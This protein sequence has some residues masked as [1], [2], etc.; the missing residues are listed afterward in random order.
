M[1]NDVIDAVDRSI[2]AQK[3]ELVTFAQDLIRMP[4][5]SGDEEA[6]AN[7][8]RSRMT[9]LGYD[10]VVVDKIGNVIGTIEGTN[11]ESPLMFNGHIDHV[12]PGD[13]DD[14][15]SA[16]ISDGKQFGV[17]GQVIL[18]RA[19]SDMKGALASM[20]MAG[21]T[22][23]SLGLKRNRPLTVACVVLEETQGLG[24]RYLA[25]TEQ[26]PSAVVVGE[27]TG[28][29]VALG[30][31]GSVGISI[32]TRGRSS[33]ASMPERGI[34]ALYKMLPIMD[35]VRDTAKDLP[36][37]SELGK[38]SM[39]ATTIS[40]SPNV[41]NVIPNSCTVGLDVRNTPNYP[42]PE[43]LR[44]LHTIIDSE[45]R[46]DPELDVGIS[47][48]RRRIRSYAGLEKE[49]EMITPSFLTA[50]DARLSQV[51]KEAASQ[52]IG[53]EAQFKI[54]Q[55]ATDGS[56]FA[57]KGIPTV[58]FGPGHER[59]AHTSQDNVSIED[60]IKATKVYTLLAAKYCS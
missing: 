43:I 50:K 35:Q 32:T 33:H 6:C 12:P 51:T 21:S 2:E 24:S 13:M 30:H 57:E 47:L 41:K 28:L 20:I 4:S 9:N 48:E 45:R 40:L 15:Y 29:D 34:N 11:R 37:H 59:F 8:I 52:Y 16:A 23:R 22:I 39:V 44:T 31:R 49:L 54:W 10:N 7:L 3:N 36:F 14:P 5:V 60:L 17:S 55:F 38:T 25:E 19:A 53:R 58:G 18:G 27:S 56:Y 46:R 26:G 1:L 42:A